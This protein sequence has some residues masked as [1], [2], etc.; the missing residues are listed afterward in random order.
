[1]A[2]RS[3]DRW[4]R[5]QAACAVWTLASIVWPAPAGAGETGSPPAA[6]AEIDFN[7]DIRPLLSDRCFSCHGPDAAK[8][9][10]GLRLDEPAGAR[11]VLDSGQRG[12]VPGDVAASGVLDRIESTDPDLVMPPP[13]VGK[14]VTAAEADLLRRWIAAGAPY[15]GHWAFERVERPAVPQTRDDTWPRTPIDRF[16]L[17]R[18]E[19][20]GMRPN[21]EAPREVLARRV[22]LDLTGLPPTPEE[23]AAL[24]ADRSPEAYESYVDQKLASLHFGERMAIEWLDAARYADSHGYQTDSS[25]SELA[26]A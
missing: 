14:P 22:S 10:A 18:L 2:R 19:A 1:M 16:I 17:A 25:R 26:V 3:R 11:L 6:V 7:R 5:V 9:Q 24:I 4:A 23:V 15:R 20:E 8:R 21:D 13:H 12:V